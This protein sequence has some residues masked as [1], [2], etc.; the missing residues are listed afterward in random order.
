MRKVFIIIGSIIILIGGFV[1][2]VFSL[3]AGLPAAADSYFSAAASGDME[4]AYT[5]TAI[6]FQ[7]EV[8][9][10]QMVDYLNST[11]LDGYVDA[12]W[13][14]RSFEN[15]WGYLEGS[16]KS[17]DGQTIPLA[18]DLLKEDGTWKIYYMELIQP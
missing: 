10:P 15:E 14:N 13:N 2:L 6:G 5:Q 8:T 16:V 4:G 9:L 7:E 3:T 18:I 17:T 1:A 11:G 12:T